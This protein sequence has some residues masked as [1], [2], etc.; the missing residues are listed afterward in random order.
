MVGNKLPNPAKLVAAGIPPVFRA[1]LPTQFMRR[2]RAV[3]VSFERGTGSGTL[4]VAMVDPGDLQALDDVRFATGLP[5]R[6]VVAREED[7]DEFLGA[8]P[9]G[10]APS[11]G[12][13]AAVEFRPDVACTVE[14]G[15]FVPEMVT[16]F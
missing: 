12:G 2:H 1:L 16:R 5:V 4:V 14:A 8:A 11:G 15:W 3:P 13:A 6:A 10:A 7:I 9:G